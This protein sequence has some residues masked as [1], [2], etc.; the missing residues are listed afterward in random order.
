MFLDNFEKFG[1][2]AD[3][4]KV[5]PGMVY[6]DLQENKNR[7]E[8][9]NAFNNGASV[10]FTTQNISDPELPVIKVNNAYETMMI[11]LNKHF[12]SPQDKAKLIAV[13]GSNDKDIV[14]DLLYKTMNKGAASNDLIGREQLEYT[15]LLKSMTIED[16]YELLNSIEPGRIH[17][18]PII[19]DYRMKY[20]RFLNSFMFDCALI[21][22]VNSFDAG[23]SSHVLNS[24]RS[25]V[26]QIPTNR[27]IIINNDDDMVLQALEKCKDNIVISYGLNKKAAVIATSIDISQSVT[28]NY[29]LQRN[30]ITNSGNVL[31]PFEIPITMNMMGSRCVY[32][33]LAV[34]TCALYYD[35]DIE[36]IKKT[37][38]NYNMPNRRFEINAVKDVYLF[39]NYCNNEGELDK[40]LEAVQML[41]YNKLDVILS[42]NK[43]DDWKSIDEIVK[44]FAQWS[45]ILRISEIILTG[46]I[47]MGSELTP[48]SITDIR[49]LKKSLL[50]FVSVKYLENL[51]DALQHAASKARAGDMLVL[52]GG[53]GMNGAKELIE[54]QLIQEKSIVDMKIL[55]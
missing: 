17:Y 45:D 12:H 1:V 51:K 54:R 48:W 50:S 5:L 46:S 6:V 32:N 34:I 47:D 52:T 27:P 53:D 18:A 2:T 38:Q 28:F 40:T 21:T 30:F 43:N 24:I 23:D 3:S 19:V 33:A 44:V 13:S 41:H 20:F 49:R 31:E 4:K 14:A 25:F 10:I 15:N 29:C 11:L 42:I 35:I 39:D 22:G 9:Y 37:L 8:L 55:H 7:K 16:I 26:S 36:Q